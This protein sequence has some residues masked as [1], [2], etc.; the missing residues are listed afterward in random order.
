MKSS[1]AFRP[2]FVI[3]AVLVAVFAGLILFD[4]ANSIVLGLVLTT[5]F[6]VVRLMGGTGS[7]LG[8]WHLSTEEQTSQAYSDQT[9]R[10]RAA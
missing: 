10:S 1:S 2:A 9:P 5:Y 3:W 7:G 4:P 6:L 8:E